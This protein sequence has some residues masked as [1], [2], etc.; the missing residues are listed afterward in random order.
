[1]TLEE[2]PHPSS[3]R[4]VIPLVVLAVVIA[5]TAWVLHRNWSDVSAAASQLEPWRLALSGLIGLV[6]T[7]TLSLVWLSSLAAYG[8]HVSLRATPVFFVTQLGKYLPGSVWPIAAQVQLSASLGAGRASTLGANLTMTLATATSGL[9][10]G[11]VLLFASAP[12]LM[13]DQWWLLLALVPMALSLHPSVVSDL[14]NWGLRRTGREPLLR[15]LTPSSLTRILALSVAFWT[16]SGLNAA[17]LVDQFNSLDLRE[18]SVTIGAV[19][20]GWAAGIIIV[21]APAGFGVRESI[22]TLALAPLIGTVPALVVA[23]ASRVMFIGAE[24][25]L[26]CV[27][28]LLWPT[29]R[30]RQD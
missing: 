14:V 6:A 25:A 20:L 29:P 24:V 12:H 10:L 17:I 21:L 8:A 1:M 22:L 18:L 26:A 4:H 16:L 30:S 11:G 3:W 19:A 9:A 23:L 7:A 2:P 5:T 15:R 13:V 28:L 27:S